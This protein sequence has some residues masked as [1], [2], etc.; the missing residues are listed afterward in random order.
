M[1]TMP[2]VRVDQ[3]IP[4]L[5]SRDAIGVHTVA[6]SDALRQVGI[7]SDIFYGECTRDLAHRAR[8]MS[9][10]GRPAKGRWLMYQASIGSPV[11]DIFASRSEP[12]LL[13][14]H[15]ITPANLLDGWEPAVGHEVSLG[16]SQVTRVAAECRLAIADSAFNEEELIDVGFKHT[17][18][19][20][21]LIDMT[22]AAEPDPVVSRRLADAK[23]D[24]GPDFL[25]V[26][27]VSPHKAQHDLVKMLALY[28]R[29][30]NDR[31]RLHFIGT[32]LGKTYGPAL[33]AFIAELRLSDAV[34]ITGSV[35]QEELESYYRSADAFVCASE[36]EGFC[37]P[38][39][40]AMG[41]GVPI[42]AYATSAVPETVGDAGLLLSSKEPLLFAASVHRVVEDA[43]LH[44]QLVEAGQARAETF[45]LANSRRRFVD[46][47]VEAVQGSARSATTRRAGG[48][49][50][51]DATCRPD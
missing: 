41:H 19:A 10:L 20:P 2:P 40:E 11:F 21:L 30:Y 4:S 32:P 14:Y 42:V 15:N 22:S 12:K 39:V 26:G 7:E 9:S 38:L 23:A 13:N 25:F 16:R 31:A 5:A 37:V 36:H 1:S 6:I 18:V 28:R 35:S 33:S 50:I 45:S 24:G 48:R 3:V 47:I 49:V 44:R 8:P 17:A 34:T 46:L 27:K 29:L 51:S 43:R